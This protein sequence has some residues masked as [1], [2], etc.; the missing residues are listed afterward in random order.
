MAKKKIKKRKNKP[1]LEQSKKDLL[2]VINQT[3]DA[4]GFESMD[5]SLLRVVLTTKDKIPRKE[6]ATIAGIIDESI[7]TGKDVNEI[8]KKENHG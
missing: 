7:I 6:P 4:R 1:T 3:A 2:Q 8:L 5:A